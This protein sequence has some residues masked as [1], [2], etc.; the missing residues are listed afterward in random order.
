MRSFLGHGTSHLAGTVLLFSC[1]DSPFADP[2]GRIVLDVR[3][4]NDWAERLMNYFP[5]SADVVESGS[6]LRLE[7][8]KRIAAELRVS[9]IYT[10]YSTAHSPAY[11]DFLHSLLSQLKEIPH[12]SFMMPNLRLRVLTDSP[13]GD[14]SVDRSLP[15]AYSFDDVTCTLN[16]PISASADELIQAI[17]EFGPA[18]VAK[19]DQILEESTII[20][21]TILKLKRRFRLRSLKQNSDVN[22]KQFMDC[23]NRLNH[24]AHRLKSFLDG[25]K[26]VVGTKY[27]LDED[28][29]SLTIRWD[30]SL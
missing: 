8:E 24:S 2:L 27:H 23:L 6:N 22:N 9:D 15:T 12:H 26:L 25:M 11:L 20:A 7:K 21:E 5:A 19:Y 28:D 3:N 14:G 30:F 18:I 17:G 13:P 29:G 16:I 1:L 4:T 10:D